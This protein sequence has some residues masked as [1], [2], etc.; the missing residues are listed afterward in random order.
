MERDG[1]LLVEVGFIFLFLSGRTGAECSDSVVG[2]SR[3]MD[4]K[5]RGTVVW[6]QSI[7]M[8]DVFGH[9]E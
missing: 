3:S 8:L 7:P 6:A 2:V 5:E 1:T 9:I 4:W